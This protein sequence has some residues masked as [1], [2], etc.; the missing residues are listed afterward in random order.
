MSSRHK[1]QNSTTAK[2]SNHHYH[3]SS[4]LKKLTVSSHRHKSEDTRDDSRQSS[5]SRHLQLPQGYREDRHRSSGKANNALSPVYESPSAE[6][7]WSRHQDHS[8]QGSSIRRT[9]TSSY[10]TI[11]EIQHA[12]AIPNRHSQERQTCELD[13]TS[14]PQSAQTSPRLRPPSIDGASMVSS[15]SSV[16]SAQTRA[17]PPI[18]KMTFDEARVQLRGLQSRLANLESPYSVNKYGPP[19]RPE[20]KKF[21]KAAA[22]LARDCDYLV[23]RAQMPIINGLTPADVL[24]GEVEV[25]W[26]GILKILIWQ[27]QQGDY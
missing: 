4:Q 11:T 10:R 19:K 20:L 23:G 12:S 21:E 9:S 22:S 13:D 15:L 3:L 2:E 27:K 6:P 1:R 25:F 16:M 14:A 17:L 8:S 18:K 24:K 26:E 5:Q 7:T